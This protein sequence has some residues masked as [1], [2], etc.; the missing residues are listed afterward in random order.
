MVILSRSRVRSFGQRT[1]GWLLIPF[2]PTGLKSEFM[3]FAGRLIQPAGPAAVAG[4]CVRPMPISVLN[5]LFWRM[6][7]NYNLSMTITIQP[8]NRFSTSNIPID[9]TRQ[10]KECGNIKISSKFRS[11]TATGK[12]S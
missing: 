2:S 7:M 12:F 1:C 9:S 5:E 10:A 8:S 6:E 11:R 3:S 4:L